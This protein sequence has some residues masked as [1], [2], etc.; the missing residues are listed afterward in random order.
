MLDV[1]FTAQHTALTVRRLAEDFLLFATEPFGYVRLHDSHCRASVHLPQKRNPYA[2][3][4]IRGGHAVV[5][6]R[7]TAVAA[8]VATGSAQTDNW[9]YNYGETLDAL[10]LARGLSALTAEVIAAATFDAARMAGAALDGF[11]EA[12][13]LAERLVAEHGIDYRTAHD[14]VG[15]AATEAERRGERRLSPADLASLARHP[16]STPDG[17]PGGPSG[18]APIEPLLAVDPRS[19]VAGRPQAG[20][21][22][23]AQVRASAR[24]LRGHLARQRAWRAGAQDRSGAVVVRLEA[25]AR[26]A[27]DSGS[28][29]PWHPS[30][31]SSRPHGAVGA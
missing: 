11:T 19:L 31:A 23:P 13:D 27:A 12:A 24:R 4:V 2:L 17:T 7:A 15:R 8:A 3:T 20:G 29:W 14:L 26:A 9:I 18:D 21:A 10:D 1:A 6:G 25:E 22:A 28:P 16:D 30:P 5:A